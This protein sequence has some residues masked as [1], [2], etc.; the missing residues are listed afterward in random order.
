MLK[1]HHFSVLWVSGWGGRGT[2]L[3]VIRRHCQQVLV[4]RR[5]L[6]AGDRCLEEGVRLDGPHV[7]LV[8]S[9]NDV[10]QIPDVEAAVVASGCEKVRRLLVRVPA[11]H[12]HVDTSRAG[13]PGD[14]SSGGASVVDLQSDG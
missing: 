7:G 3:V 11:Q 6:N 2:N 9:A 10:T 5:P 14:L 12:V 13:L 8:L 4:C 1:V